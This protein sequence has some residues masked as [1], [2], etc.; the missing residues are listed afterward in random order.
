[1]EKRDYNKKREKESPI[2]IFRLYN[3]SFFL[4]HTLEYTFVCSWVGAE[5]ASFSESKPFSNDHGP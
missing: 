4:I 2:F 1:M 3:F 5:E